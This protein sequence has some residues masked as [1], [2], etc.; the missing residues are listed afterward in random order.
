MNIRFVINEPNLK[1]I[2]IITECFNNLL[3]KMLNIIGNIERERK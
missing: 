2:N 3:N 1:T